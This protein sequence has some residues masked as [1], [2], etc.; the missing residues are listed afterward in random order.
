VLSALILFI[1]SLL[2]STSAF[3][4]FF[5]LMGSLASLAYPSI[6]VLALYVVIGIGLLCGQ[7]RNLNLLAIG[8]ATA[9]TLGLDV[10]H[11]KRMIFC[12]SSWLSGASGGVIGVIGF[13]RLW[14]AD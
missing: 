14:I 5:W 10:E 13:G 7:A 8:E 12:T 11:A 6:L 2:D 4:L 9:Q 3:R 1:S